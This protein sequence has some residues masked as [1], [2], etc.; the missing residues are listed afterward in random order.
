M[1]LLLTLTNNK[2]QQKNIET[3]RTPN[4]K[5]EHTPEL[6]LD[7]VTKPFHGTVSRVVLDGGG[8]V[9]QP[10]TTVSA[11]KNEIIITGMD[12]SSFTTHSVH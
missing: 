12:I 8:Y 1:G 7:S 2:V 4:L 5:V 10:T 11:A 3:G 9:L 6:R